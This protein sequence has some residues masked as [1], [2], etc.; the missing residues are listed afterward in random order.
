[1]SQDGYLWFSD[2]EIAVFEVIYETLKKELDVI[3]TSIQ[4]TKS[5]L[6][7]I[8]ERKQ[9]MSILLRINNSNINKML[10]IN[11]INNQ[12]SIYPFFQLPYFQKYE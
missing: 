10:Y 1:M 12:F 11:Y 5:N 8:S 3:Y 7:F 2:G 6:E 9:R 4:K